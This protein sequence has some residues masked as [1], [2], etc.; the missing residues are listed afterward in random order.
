MFGGDALSTG[1]RSAST[2]SGTSTF[3]EI[4]VKAPKGIL[5][6]SENVSITQIESE[7]NLVDFSDEFLQFRIEN[8][9]DNIDV[10]AFITKEGTNAKV[11]VDLIPE[12]VLNG[13]R[14]LEEAFEELRGS[15]G[16]SIIELK[17]QI[18]SQLRSQGFKT[19]EIFG[20]RETGI[21]KGLIQSS[22]KIDLNK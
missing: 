1:S 9:V 20:K 10:F 4:T 8:S 2:S 12:S 18:E 6:A 15:F 22:G 21:N 17:G 11:K 3:S 16:S 7:V 5:G 19:A 13:T 14:T